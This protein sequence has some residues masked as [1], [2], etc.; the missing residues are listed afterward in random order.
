MNICKELCKPDEIYPEVELKPI[1][2]VVNARSLDRADILQAL[3][4]YV[5]M[6][7]SLAVLFCAQQFIRFF[8]V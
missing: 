8:F 3:E 7:N 2:V 1:S 5:Y 4:K 6:S